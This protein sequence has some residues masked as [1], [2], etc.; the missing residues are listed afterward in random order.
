MYQLYILNWLVKRQIRGS[1]S[2]KTT[3]GITPYNLYSR[4]KTDM[5]SIH[6]FLHNT[7]S[8]HNVDTNRNCPINYRQ[9][10][11]FSEYWCQNWCT[12]QEMLHHCAADEWSLFVSSSPVSLAVST[13]NLMTKWRGTELKLTRV[14][15]YRN[16]WFIVFLQ[17]SSFTRHQAS[18]DCHPQ[19]EIIGDSNLVSGL[20]NH[21]GP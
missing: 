3:S 21:A 16:W 8:D 19:P 1:W 20:Y 5:L 2:V 15:R 13:M 17:I 11:T 18:S 14:K 12:L 7:L 9:C 4:D 6:I 10:I